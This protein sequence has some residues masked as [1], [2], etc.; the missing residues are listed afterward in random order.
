MSNM[1]LITFKAGICDTDFG[2]DPPRVTPRPTPGY[3]YLYSDDDLPHLCWRPRSA[4]ADQPELDLLIPPGDAQF[5]PYDPHKKSSGSPT[6]PYTNGRI[7]V[8]RFMGS[9]SRTLFWLQSK[10]QS[11][12]DDSSWFSARDLKLVGLVDQI[13]QGE[14]V[15]MP[16]AIDEIRAANAEGDD[17]DVMEDIEGTNPPADHYRGGSGGAGPD[18]TGGDVREEGEGPREGG[19]DGGRAPPSTDASALVQNLL[20]SLQGDPRVAAGSGRQQPQPQ[21]FTTLPDLLPAST[22][23]PVIES[24]TE[25]HLDTLLSHLPPVLLF[26]ETGLSDDTADE[27]DAEAR[28]VILQSLT[29]DQKR[30]V[31]RKVLHSPQFS[32]SLGSLT[33]ALRDG[34]LPVISDA[35]G[36]EVQNSGFV[37]RGG[38]PLGGDEAVRAFI[39]GARRAVEGE[40]KEEEGE[41][42]METD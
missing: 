7:I 6:K 25:S 21:P 30:S 1:P 33:V 19:A 34:G 12:T 26:V 20:Q 32:Q 22:T 42:R 39:E 41:D 14:D 9:D 29:I 36:I 38:M 40:E 37:R 8:L 16:A 3:L 27:P 28:D 35:L 5:K 23:I 11:A 4:P 10:N 31:L 2:V 17:D 24:A 15:N 18:A 13:L